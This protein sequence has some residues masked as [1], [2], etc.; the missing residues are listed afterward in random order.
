M[1]ARLRVRGVGGRGL[2]A[3]GPDA[4][5]VR[6]DGRGEEKTS[7]TRH[8]LRRAAAASGYSQYCHWPVSNT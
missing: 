1:E 4:P 2:R 6:S 3:A 8:S 5:Q 7:I